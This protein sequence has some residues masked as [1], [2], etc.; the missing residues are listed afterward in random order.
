M[1][2]QHNYSVKFG[3][4]QLLVEHPA[5][6]GFFGAPCG[7]T[8]LTRQVQTNTNDVELPP[9]NDPDAIIWLGIDPIS[10][11]M[12]VT[13]SGT[14]ADV[15]M[16]IW[17]SWAMEDEALR[18][19]RWYRN[20][21]EP[22]RGYWEGYA[23]LTDYQEESS[24]RARYTNSGTVIFD[25][26]PTWVDIPPAPNLITKPTIPT[27]APEVG[28]AFAVTPGVYSAPNP[29]LTYQWYKNGSLIVGADDPSYT[30]VLADIGA[31]IYVIENATN[32]GGQTS[33][34]T[35]FSAPVVAATP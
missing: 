33:T 19:V 30:P 15:A 18:R 28:E 22:N 13:F 32:I 27:T 3:Q 23:V 14:L 2:E 34:P 17:D 11:R 6:S 16:Q 1:S 7:I 20:L 5:G 4:Q 9:C 8:G 26:K 29:A 25:G 10:K 12:T 35:L 21:D 24:G 31:R